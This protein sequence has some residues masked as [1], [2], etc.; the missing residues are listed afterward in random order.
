MMQVF[1]DTYTREVA[2]TVVAETIQTIF[3]IK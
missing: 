2:F 3:I 1:N